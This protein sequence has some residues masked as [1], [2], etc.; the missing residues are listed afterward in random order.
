MESKPKL[1]N[2]KKNSD[3]LELRKKGLRLNPSDWLQIQ[4]MK[5]KDGG[6][7]VGV[8]T[9]RKVGSAVIR[10]RLKRWSRE[11]FR[12]GLQLGPIEGK[13]NVVFKPRPSEFYKELKHEDLDGVL[14]KAFKRIRELA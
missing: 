1:K 12:K 14:D 13:L 5:S 11:F 8:T 4:F 7:F 2:L 3:F 6:L 10:N 9:G